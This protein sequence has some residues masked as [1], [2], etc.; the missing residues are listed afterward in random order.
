[1]ALAIT[2]RQ[3]AGAALALAGRAARAAEPAD[4]AR[5]LTLAQIV[6]LT[7]GAALA[8][9][10]FRNGVE[11]AIQE[12]NGAAGLGGRLIEVV[13]FDAPSS[14]AGGRLA[15]QRALELD[16]LAVLGPALA[17]AARG[18]LAVPRAR[19]TP[20]ILGG[21]A[22]DL[23]A[24]LTFRPLPSAGTMMGRLCTWLRDDMQVKRLALYWSSREPYRSG[25][26]A[27]L[28]E[29]RAVGI[30]FAEWIAESGEPAA[31]LPRLLNAGPDLLVALVAQDLAARTI[32]EARRLA[33]SL[34]VIGDASLIDPATLAAAGTA[35]EGVRAHVLLQPQPTDGFGARYLAA[36][37]SPPDELALAGYLSVGM[38]NAALH[39]AGDADA[40]S[41]A[42]AL[43]DRSDRPSWIVEV[44]AGKP[45]VV[46]KLQGLG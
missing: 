46:A 5:P 14:F 39:K 26:N 33:P 36:N 12:I 2:R 3:L 40:R 23:T 19:A 34:P 8:G 7:G 9:D 32:V 37:K 13:T 18:A 15:M 20:L 21:N 29:A 42:A 25:R 30:A 10:A 16:P 11:L 1:M 24:P 41:F 28:R 31:D 43:A 35:A 4:A 27:L 45:A 38:V 6:E 22:G 17:E 44:R